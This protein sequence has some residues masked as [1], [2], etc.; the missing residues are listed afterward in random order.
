[1]FLVVGF[2]KLDVDSGGILFA[3]RQLVPM[4]AELEGVA[5]RRTF[6]ELDVGAGN[7]AHIEEMLAQGTLS[8]HGAYARHAVRFQ[9][10]ECGQLVFLNV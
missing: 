2:H 3:Q 6:H 4:D 8:S 9:F 10:V 5:H 1:M 7:N